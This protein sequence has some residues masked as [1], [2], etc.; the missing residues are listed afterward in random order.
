MTASSTYFGASP[1]PAT[2]RRTSI[3]TL[4][5]APCAQ[6]ITAWPQK[7]ATGD[8]RIGVV[9]LALM[10]DWDALTGIALATDVLATEV[11]PATAASTI[12]LAAINLWKLLIGSSC[13]RL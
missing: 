7:A 11:A 12:E 9:E 1:P 10:L 4:A 8:S 13:L 3:A 5:R 2:S 6:E